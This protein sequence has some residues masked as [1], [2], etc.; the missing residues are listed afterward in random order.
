MEPAKHR[1]RHD[2][3]ARLSL[4]SQPWLARDALADPLVRTA[5]VE[6][7]HPFGQD[8]T[9]VILAED[10]DVIEALAS[11]GAEKSLTDGVQVGRLRRDRDDVD[12]RAV[13]S[14]GKVAPKLPVVV[15]DQEP[16]RLVVRGRLSQLLGDP[17]IGRDA[18]DVDVENLAAL[19]GDD[20]EG[21][22]RPEPGVV[23]LQEIAGPNS[24]RVVLKKGLPGLPRPVARA[25]GPHIL[26]DLP[27][28]DADPE[29]E[30]FAT[31][32]FGAPEHV[33]TGHGPNQ[34]DDLGAQ[35]SGSV[36]P[37]GLASPEEGEQVAMP[38]E[39]GV[40][41]NQ[42]EGVAPRGRHVGQQHQEESVLSVEA[43]PRYEQVGAGS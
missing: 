20:E 30:Q 36:H 13:G 35:P 11:Q 5:G 19:V 22:D 25:D 2:L 32:P 4:I 38:A 18:R 1:E 17:G 7:L 28:A 27:L 12:A 21:V 10:Q 29:L 26:L 16:W 14:G 37:S 43:R 23:E 40:G 34:V 6:V 39:E 24:R 41:L 8:P 9:K 3:A 31:D 15:S 42:M 33:S